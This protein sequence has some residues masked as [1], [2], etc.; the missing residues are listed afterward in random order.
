[1]T[2]N[3]V[4]PPSHFVHGMVLQTVVKV[5][6]VDGDGAAL[7]SGEMLLGRDVVRV[8]VDLVRVTVE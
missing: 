2:A 3:V 1:M 5:V 6:S 8:K 4:E 7:V